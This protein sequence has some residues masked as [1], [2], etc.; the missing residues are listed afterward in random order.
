MN[1]SV[2]D[3]L[4][5]ALDGRLDAPAILGSRDLLKAYEEAS[6]N[7]VPLDACPDQSLFV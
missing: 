3:L 4:G 2:R 7:V 6:T 5:Q 1:W